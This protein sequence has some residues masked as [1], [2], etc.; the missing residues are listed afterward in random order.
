MS[1]FGSGDGPGNRLSFTE[2]G[3]LQ[4]FLY[5]ANFGCSVSIFGSGG[6]PGNRLSFTEGGH[7]Q[8]SLTVANLEAL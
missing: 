8:A 3:H 5:V 6:C 2:G 4:T 1:I 7:L